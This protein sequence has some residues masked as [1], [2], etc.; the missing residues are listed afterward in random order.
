MRMRLAF[1]PTLA[2]LSAWLTQAGFAAD[3]RPVNLLKPPT[4]SV[5]QDGMVAADPRNWQPLTDGDSSTTATA[6][7]SEESPL[8]IVYGFRGEIVTPERLVVTL[9]QK[10]A[11]AAIPVRVEL[12]VSNLSPHAGFQTVRSDPLSP[13]TKPQEFRFNAIGARWVMLRFTPAP[14]A[15]QVAVNEVELFGQLGPPATRYAFKESPARALEVL[16]HLKGISSLDLSISADEASLFADAKDGRFDTWSFAEAALLVSSVQSKEERQG[17]L[18]TLDKIEA[19]A[20]KAV[21]TARNPFDQGAELLRFLHSGPLS[22]GYVSQQTDLSQVLAKRTFNCVSSATLYN[23]IGRRLKLDLRA[24]EVPNHAFSILYD[25]TK[26]A[27]VETTT[28]AGFNPARDSDAR[29]EFTRLTG[30]AYIPDSNRDERRE[31]GEV[32][33]VAIICYNHGVEFMQGKRYHEALLA[34]FRAMSLD[35]EFDSAVKNALA[36]LAN[37]SAELAQ[38][39]KFEE[40]VKVVAAGLELAPQDATLV[41][42][43][44]AVWSQ[45][46][47]ALTA[48]GKVD[49]ALAVLRRAA[50]ENPK[51]RFLDMQAWVFIRSGEE[52]VKSGDWD[53]AKVIVEPGLRKLEGGPREELVRWSANLP[54]RR[55]ASE[56]EKHNYEAA[57][58]VLAEAFNS[59]ANDGRLREHVAYVVQEWAGDVYRRDGAE[60]AEA[61]IADCLRRF[62]KCK[63]VIDVARNHEGRIVKE[64][65][66]KA[67]Y[68]DALAVAERAGQLLKD[69]SV[70]LELARSI[71]DNW[72]R[73]QS[74]KKDWQAAVDIYG[75]ALKRWPKDDHLENNQVAAWHAW[76]KSCAERKDWSAATGV[77]AKALK[78]LRDASSVEHNICYFTQEW[79]RDVYADKGAD[80]SVQILKDQMALFPAVKELQEVAAGHLQR[81]SRDLSEK[82]KFEEAV[83]VVDIAVQLLKDENSTTDIA[84]AVYDTWARTFL[85]K[86]DFEQAVGV[87]RKAIKKF[88]KNGHLQQNAA[89][90][91]DGWAKTRMEKKDWNGAIKIYE[92][93]REMLPDDSVLKNNLEYC[94]EQLKKAKE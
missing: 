53:K 54:H 55:A 11:A 56:L 84:G 10:D 14:K 60:R 29:Q 6:T 57:I 46:A 27:D 4:A 31:V 59:K 80:A 69:Q 72:A 43:H 8:T 34:Y 61:V 23:V 1:C 79:A 67:K 30:F 24:V 81:V 32:G 74:E 91:W 75:R 50:Q 42:N 92:L 39:K 94:R 20:R 88:P 76:A 44:E 21:G 37:W 49:E 12:L 52:L 89:A 63:D 90:T 40:A 58:G 17:Y 35:P 47:E 19:E 86:D 7:A 38:A 28:A 73:E 36:V 64:L 71:Y 2:F 9:P 70:T 77:Y 26:H 48:D 62:P 85:T 5:E 87:Y 41:H 93:S 33:L 78:E 25:G 83:A 65:V 51:G 22:Q 15:K 13:T 3:S 16:E 18:K 45:W 82:G 66:S 68:P